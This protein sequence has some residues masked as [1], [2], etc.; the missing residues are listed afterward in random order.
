[1]IISCPVTGQKSSWRDCRWTVCINSPRQGIENRALPSFID[2]KMHIFGSLKSGLLSQ[3]MASYPYG[4]SEVKAGAP[5]DDH[6]ASASHRGHPASDCLT[7]DFLLEVLLDST[8]CV[9]EERKLCKCRKEFCLSTTSPRLLFSEEDFSTPLPSVRTSLVV[10][11]VKNPPAM[12]ETR[13]W[14][15]GRED[16]LEKEWLPTPVF[17]P[18]EFHGQRSLVSY[19]PR[20]CKESDV[21]ERLSD[22]VS[23]LKRTHSLAFPS[24]LVALFLTS[25]LSEGVPALCLVFSLRLPI[26]GFFLNLFWGHKIIT[27]LTFGENMVSST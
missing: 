12:R 20:G 18:G 7:L 16:P 6:T 26:L 4:G 9:N 17:L 22:P 24:H 21:T 2:S 19:S 14:S 25:P 1:M 13:V 11:T 10:Q 27:H 15:L 8:N 3:T 23:S 5:G